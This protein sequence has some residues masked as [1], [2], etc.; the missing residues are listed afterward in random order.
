MRFPAA[1]RWQLPDAGW[2]D[3]IN[4]IYRILRLLRALLLLVL[5]ILSNHL[6]GFDRLLLLQGAIENFVKSRPH[7]KHP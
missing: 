1:G 2:L 3:R 4:R 5:L 6:L 7:L